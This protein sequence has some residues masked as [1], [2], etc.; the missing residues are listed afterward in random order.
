MLEEKLMIERKS[1]R[2]IK[3]YNAHLQGLFFALS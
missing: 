3:S 2:T 1:W